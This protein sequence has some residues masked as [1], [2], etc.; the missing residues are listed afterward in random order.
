MISNRS[1]TIIL[2]AIISVV[3]LLITA[4]RLDQASWDAGSYS[5]EH[6]KAHAADSGSKS[7]Q[8]SGLNTTAIPTATVT[9]T[10]EPTEAPGHVFT[11]TVTAIHTQTIAQTPSNAP[12]YAG[13]KLSV[14]E[15]RSQL[16][17]A[18]ASDPVCDGFPDTSRILLVMKTGATESYDRLPVQIMT[19]LKCLPDYLIFSDLAQMIGGYHVRDSLDNVLVEAQDGNSDF[20]LYRQQQEC[21]V[22]Q[23]SCSDIF[24]GTDSAGWNLDKYKNIHMAE[25]SYRLRPNYDWYV[26]VD[27]DTYVSWP[28]MVYGL[29]QLDPTQESYYGIPTVIG[30]RL[31]A[32]GGSGYVLSRGLMNEFVGKNPGIANKYDV[33]M[34]DNCCGDFV[35]AMALKEAT[36]I[37][38]HGFVSASLFKSRASIKLNPPSP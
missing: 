10:A 32:H 4:K 23:A 5:T 36:D 15:D 3:V 6:L 7:Q 11:V 8:E 33:E 37:S 13:S 35:F 14:D 28:N 9:V 26:F 18:P 30:S 31:F 38:V 1:F 27:A 17:L 19:I 12:L 34:K 20:D 29:S 21:V 24:E 16:P 25:K 22:D 2:F